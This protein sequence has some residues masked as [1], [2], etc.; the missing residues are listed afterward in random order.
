M[1]PPGPFRHPVQAPLL[2]CTGLALALHGLLLASATPWWSAPAV[3]LGGNR[4]AMRASLRQETNRQEAAAATASERKNAEPAAAAPAPADPAVAGDEAMPDRLPGLP[5]G[6]LL[7]PFP[8]L[9]RPDVP[10][11]L[12]LL[13]LLDTSGMPVE[14]LSDAKTNPALAPFAEASIHALSRQ[15][16]QPAYRAGQT[17]AASLCLD[18]VF[19][20]TAPAAELSVVTT[21]GREDCL[22][23]PSD[24]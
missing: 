6:E 15:R 9:P 21:K 1:S 10:L 11:R 17:Q 18:V 3:Q 16:Y 14:I 19:G 2:V 22:R 23:A 7:I 12:R 5:D 13:L 20:E 24:S 8:D 4:P